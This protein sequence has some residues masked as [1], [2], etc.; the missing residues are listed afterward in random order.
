MSVEKTSTPS[1]PPEVLRY[2]KEPIA[3][4]KQ[5]DF[6][7]GEWDADAV[8]YKEDGTPFKYKAKWSAL[9]LNGGRMIMD[10]FKALGPTG[11]P[12]SS[13]VTLRTYSETTNRWEL[14]GLQA[15]QPSVPTEWHGIAKAGEMLLTKVP[16]LHKRVGKVVRM[17][18]ISCG[19]RPGCAG[20]EGSGP[21]HWSSRLENGGSVG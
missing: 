5:F 8:R 12:V 2:M 3:E 9:H 4:S 20:G 6:L 10:D 14:V 16:W 13:F 18:A 1:I 15:L 7:I 11:Q 19:W 17:Q 21:T